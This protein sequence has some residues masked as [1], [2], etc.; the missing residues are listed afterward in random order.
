MRYHTMAEIERRG[1]EP[2]LDRIVAEAREEGVDGENSRVFAK[3]GV[4]AL[5]LAGGPK[6]TLDGI[7]D[8]LG[9][10]GIEASLAKIPVPAKPADDAKKDT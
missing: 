9:K 7:L 5:K 8:S 10:A 1:W 2:V 3:R 4:I 6:L